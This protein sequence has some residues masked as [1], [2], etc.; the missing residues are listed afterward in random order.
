MLV[1]QPS[2][3]RCEH[4]EFD[5]HL[6]K[7]DEVVLDVLQVVSLLGRDALPPF[8]KPE[9]RAFLV[10]LVVADCVE[11]TKAPFGGHFPDTEPQAAILSEWPTRFNRERPPSP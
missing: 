4:F 2:P 7:V 3:L 6:T 1:A 8:G 9:P 10:L 11:G 5:K